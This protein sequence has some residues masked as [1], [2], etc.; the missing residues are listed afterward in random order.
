MKKSLRKL[1]C[2][3]KKFK[4]FNDSG[5]AI[6]SSRDSAYGTTLFPFSFQLSK[7]QF[8]LVNTLKRFPGAW[9]FPDL[10]RLTSTP[11]ESHFPRKIKLCRNSDSIG[12][13]IL[14]NF[15]MNFPIGHQVLAEDDVSC[16]EVE[17]LF[18]QK[19]SSSKNQKKIQKIRKK[20]EKSFF[21]RI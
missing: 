11:D 21:L 7:L 10:N 15:S 14:S 13:R 1:N 16:D 6:G 2:S 4:L 5:D 20:P 18:I 8:Q 17:G 9:E 12:I 19:Y 3:K